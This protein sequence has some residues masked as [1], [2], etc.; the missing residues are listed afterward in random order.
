MK[1][2][3]TQNQYPKL[4]EIIFE[5]FEKYKEEK[6]IFISGALLFKSGFYLDEKNILHDKKGNIV[7]FT[8]MTNAGNIERESIGVMIKEDLAQLGIKVN[9]KPIEF[10]VLIGKLTGSLDWEAIIM[11]LTGSALEPNNGVVEM[12][13]ENNQIVYTPDKNFAGKEYFTVNVE[14]E[15]GTV[16]KGFV[17]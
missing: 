12:D 14:T 10:N 11:G 6:A 5:L 7:E 13:E 3:I 15:N 17:K 16:V 8:L 9:F 2:N 4:K 1:I